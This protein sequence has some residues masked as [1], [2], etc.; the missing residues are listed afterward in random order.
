M[1]LQCCLTRLTERYDIC[2]PERYDANHHGV[3]LM[4]LF[5]ATLLFLD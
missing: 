1:G 5:H 3:W 4:V 2:L